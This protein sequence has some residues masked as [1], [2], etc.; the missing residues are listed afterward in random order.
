MRLGPFGNAWDRQLLVAASL[1][2]VDTIAVEREDAMDS[3]ALV[4]GAG[5]SEEET[6]LG[7]ALGLAYLKSAMRAAHPEVETTLLN[8]IIDPDARTIRARA[9]ARAEAGTAPRDE[10]AQGYRDAEAVAR[11]VADRNPL[12]CGVSLIYQ[13]Q[14]GWTEAFADTL[15]KL[16][17]D[18][19][20]VVG[21]MYSTSA[22]STLLQDLRSVDSVCL[23][24]GDRVFVQLYEAL[25]AGRDFRDV[26]GLAFRSADGESVGAG[27]SAR[28]WKMRRPPLAALSPAEL[29]ELPFPDRGQLDRVRELGGVIQVE[30]SRGCNATCTFCD[31]RLTGWRPRPVP[32]LVA[33]LKELSD[34]YPG[35]LIYLVNN[36]FLGFS[37]DGSHLARG[38]ELARAI[39]AEQLPVR[40]V[41]QDRAANIDRETF[42]LLKAA[43]LCEVYLGIESFADSALLAIGKGRDAN[44]ATNVQA[45]RTLGELRL[46][47]QFGFLPFHERVTF[48]ELRTTV[49]GLEQACTGNAYLHLSNFN[50]LIP[51]EGTYLARRYERDHRAAPP[52]RN[53]WQYS[54]PRIWYFR[55]WMWRFSG[56]LWP[57]T[58][59]IF[60]AI[61]QPDYQR[62]LWRT[63]PTKNQAYVEFARYLLDRAEAEAL[64][65]SFEAE[66][67]DASFEAEAFEATLPAYRAAVARMVNSI[68]ITL[69]DWQPGPATEA[70]VAALDAVDAE[71]P[72]TWLLR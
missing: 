49:A 63:L 4:V 23:G 25:R 15:K 48:E 22:W 12:L 72:L 5:G 44:A 24:E 60:H 59:Q 66:A 10:L 27:R 38:R 65:A 2:A 11:R 69:A 56:A 40:F 71:Q 39:L 7:E 61:Q 50:E 45:L 20:I 57:V 70:M 52:T 29:G 68:R 35:A 34:R 31:A 3:V 19:H 43:G 54:D 28:E 17:P 6:K 36:I 58:G 62:D 16:L 64:D 51:Y 13:M 41:I 21:G 9:R 55:D 46:Y 32:H 37:T 26:A 18:C 42:E 30:A 8:A 1:L 33:E 14:R 47:T 53:P 67:F